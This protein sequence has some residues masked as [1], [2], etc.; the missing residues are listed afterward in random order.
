MARNTDS[1]RPVID[2]HDPRVVAT[3]DRYW[4]ANLRIMAVLLVVWAAVGLGCG[5]LLANSLNQYRL[6]GFPLGFWFAQQGSI[7]TFVVL[8]FVYALLL[9]RLDDRHH[10]ELERLRGGTGS[11]GGK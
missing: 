8:I 11:E 4:R 10:Q 5:V 2:V 9:N 6:G 7:L 1:D 3:I